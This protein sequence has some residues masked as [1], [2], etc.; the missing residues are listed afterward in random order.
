MNAPAG[1]NS[2]TF[3]EIGGD[4][5]NRCEKIQQVVSVPGLQAAAV[6]NIIENMW[7]KFAMI[8]GFGVFSVMRGDKQTICLCFLC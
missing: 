4:I 1:P 3:G 6:P 7:W 8:C 5:T 2:I